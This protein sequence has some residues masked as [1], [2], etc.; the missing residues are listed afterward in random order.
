MTRDDLPP[1]IQTLAQRA[2]YNNLGK[3]EALAILLDDVIRGV[4]KADWRGNPPRENEIKYEI[5]KILEDESE[6]ERIF[7]IIKQQ[8]EY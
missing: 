7:A 6:V 5:Y 1:R 2:L 4:K 3:N 8:N